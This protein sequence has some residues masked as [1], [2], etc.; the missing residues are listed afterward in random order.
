[1]LRKMK[2]ENIMKLEKQA[3]REIAKRQKDILKRLKTDYK[4]TK[5]AIK[6]NWFYRQVLSTKEFKKIDTMTETQVTNILKEAIKK[7]YQKDLQNALKK[8][9]VIKS[10]DFKQCKWGVCTIDWVKNRTWG[11]CPRGE[12][13]NG[14]DYK[15]YRSVTG[16][17]YDKLSTL[18]AEMFND[19][20]FLLSYIAHYIETH[21]VNDDNI[22]EKLGY[23]IHLSNGKPYFDGGVGVSCHIAILKKLGFKVTH[24][25]TRKSDYIEYSK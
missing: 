18:T 21:A 9:A 17:G 3:K 20:L 1:M 25:E 22:R 14:H 16:C 24:N 12:Y 7:S 5:E 8:I 23:G 6:Q 4:S 15:E 10:Y 13:R 11:N 2:G 19:D